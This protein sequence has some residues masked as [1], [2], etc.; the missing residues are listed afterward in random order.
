MSEITA[1]C[2]QAIP[3][4]QGL[5]AEELEPLCAAMRRFRLRQGEML[6]QRGEAGTAMFVIEE[7][8]VKIYTLGEAERQIVLNILGPNDVLGEMTL[9]DGKPRSA[10]GQAMTDSTLLALDRDPF[11]HH[12]RHHPDTSLHLLAYLSERMRQIVLQTETLSINDSASRL[13][14]TLLF[15][16][17]RDGEVERG[18][19]T[20]T[21]R[22]KDLAAAIGTSEEW[23]TQTL[24]EW[25]HDGII[26]MP[27]SRRLLL[28]D[29][30]MLRHLSRSES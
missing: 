27:S 29:V 15:L 6:F 21:L 17:E 7:G 30:E 24:N 28:H 2:L 12:L 16:A 13:A 23:V 4:F 26:G 19:V 25:S 10:Y 18:L 3:L 14:H 9:L 20:S 11:L 1:D 22:K 5:P 8:K